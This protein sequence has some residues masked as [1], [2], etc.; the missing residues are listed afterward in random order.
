MASGGFFVEDGGGGE[1]Q[2]VVDVLER[3]VL[4]GIFRGDGGGGGVGAGRGPRFVGGHAQAGL[5]AP[6]VDRHVQSER[7]VTPD[8]RDRRNRGHLIVRYAV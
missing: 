8:R 1:G 2:V 6:R 3:P 4:G 5:V 7:V